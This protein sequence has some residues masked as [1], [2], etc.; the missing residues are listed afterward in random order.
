MCIELL[1]FQNQSI[2]TV[3]EIGSGHYCITNKTT[4]YKKPVVSASDH[5][6]VTISSFTTDCDP[7]QLWYIWGEGYYFHIRNGSGKYLVVSPSGAYS[8]VM[9]RDESQVWIVEVVHED[10]NFYYRIYANGT[11]RF[12]LVETSPDPNQIWKIWQMGT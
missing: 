1:P 5:S 6:T 10:C 12:Q 2:T 11:P 8:S 9:G 4:P 3:S 7:H